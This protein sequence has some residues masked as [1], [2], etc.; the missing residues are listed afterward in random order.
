MT[1][2][3]ILLRLGKIIEDCFNVWDV[4]LTSASQLSHFAPDELDMILF[5]SEIDLEF[6]LDL[7]EKFPD[8]VCVP[9]GE[10]VEYIYQNQK[11]N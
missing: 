1:R 11:N 4:T 6:R 9:I 7:E 2:T 10:I 8:P 5:L 3:D